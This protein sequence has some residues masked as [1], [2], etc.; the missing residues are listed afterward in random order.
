MVAPRY[1]RTNRD[2]LLSGVTAQQDLKSGQQRHEQAGS[3][4]LA[5]KLQRLEKRVGKNRPL[6]CSPV[7]LS[8]RPGPVCGQLQQRWS[9]HELLPPV[10]DL[11]IP[12]L[13][14]RPIA[15]P[16]GKITVLNW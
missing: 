1:R 3:S 11:L 4:P 16:D 12:L 7:A 6:G 13:S 2:V 5:Q 15:L 10:T 8:R 14:L 9:P